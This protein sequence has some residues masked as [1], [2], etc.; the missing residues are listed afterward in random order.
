[1]VRIPF[2]INFVSC[3][4]NS[5]CFITQFAKFHRRQKNRCTE[6]S[7]RFRLKGKYAI[8]GVSRPSDKVGG[9]GTVTKRKFFS[10]L[11]AFFWSGPSPGSATGNLFAEISSLKL[12]YF[13]QYC[14]LLKKRLRGIP[15][16]HSPL[17]LQTYNV[18]LRTIHF[19]SIS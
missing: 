18:I 15:L 10:A 11:W 14:S 8:S 5:F 1:M 16:G 7:S 13:A 17:H 3:R 19:L 12:I 4:E 2:S 6:I 9:G